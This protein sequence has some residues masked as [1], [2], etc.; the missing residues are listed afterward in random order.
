MRLKM[1][2]MKGSCLLVSDKADTYAVTHLDGESEEHKISFL[3][4]RHAVKS[5]TRAN[6]NEKNRAWIFFWV[7]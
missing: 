4:H 7:L 3:L 1:N 5:P 6:Y 2:V